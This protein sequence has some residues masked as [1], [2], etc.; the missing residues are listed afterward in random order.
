MLENLNK[1]KCAAIFSI[2]RLQAWWGPQ[3]QYIVRQ[4]VKPKSL[5]WEVE[6]INGRVMRGLHLLTSKESK[7]NV[8]VSW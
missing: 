4:G 7:S 8:K 1:I 5:F 3:V 2:N 6:V